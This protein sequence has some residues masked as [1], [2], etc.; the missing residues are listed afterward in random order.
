MFQRI[1]CSWTL[2]FGVFSCAAFEVLHP[3]ESELHKQT[4]ARNMYFASALE[5]KCVLVQL[6]SGEALKDCQKVGDAQELLQKLSVQVK[7]LPVIVEENPCLREWLEESELTIALTKDVQAVIKLLHDAMEQR[8]LDATAA[9]AKLE[10]T[11]K[12]KDTVRD[13]W[14]LEAIMSAAQKSDLLSMA[15]ASA[16]KSA[17]QR[18]NKDNSRRHSCTKFKNYHFFSPLLVHIWSITLCPSTQFSFQTLSSLVMGRIHFLYLD[19]SSPKQDAILQCGLNTT[20]QKP[21]TYRQHAQ[22]QE[23]QDTRSWCEAFGMATP[24]SYHDTEI[25]GAKMAALTADALFLSAWSSQKLTKAAK[26]EK[27]TATTKK[28]DLQTSFY[29]SNVKHFVC[30]QLLQEVTRWMLHS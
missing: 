15:F 21:K 17:L 16:H 24:S 8:L 11:M 22:T 29:H 14:T 19:S 10:P 27:I 30:Q 1:S 5:Q 18:I 4:L 9:C 7:R 3:V 12:W 25:M 20:P 28:M 26:T 13:G 23:L 6:L 2:D